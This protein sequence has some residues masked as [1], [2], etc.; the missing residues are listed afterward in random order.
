[1]LARAGCLPRTSAAARRT[2]GSGSFSRLFAQLSKGR[3]DLGSLGECLQAVHAQ[4]A[5]RVAGAGQKRRVVERVLAVQHPE[6]VHSL[7]RG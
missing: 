1:M 3:R 7:A 5:V 4:L 6:R 2:N